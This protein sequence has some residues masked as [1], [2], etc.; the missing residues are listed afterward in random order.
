MLPLKWYDFD[1]IKTIA[2]IRRTGLLFLHFVFVPQG[3][4]YTLL[5]SVI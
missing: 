3:S 1:E 4:C 2:K 5:I